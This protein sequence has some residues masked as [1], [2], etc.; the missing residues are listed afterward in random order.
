MYLVVRLSCYKI[1]IILVYKK[2]VLVS[3]N[4]QNEEYSNI[5]YLLLTN[6]KEASKGT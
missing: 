2:P 1:K 5:F 4:G 3:P 6:W